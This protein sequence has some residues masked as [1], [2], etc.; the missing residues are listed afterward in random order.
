LLPFATGTALAGADLAFAALEAF[1]AGDIFG[2]NAVF[3][4]VVFVAFG[5]CAETFTFGA[6]L[7]TDCLFTT[8]LTTGFAVDVSLVDEVLTGEDFADEAAGFFFAT[9]FA[10]VFVTLLFVLAT[11]FAVVFAL[12]ISFLAIFLLDQKSLQP[13]IIHD[14]DLFVY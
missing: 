4:D 10:T 3:V 11:G 6:A 1:A 5:D 7:L 13:I 14:F 12:G 9:G 2:F 8:F